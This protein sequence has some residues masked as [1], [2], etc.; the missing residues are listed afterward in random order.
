MGNSL[1]QLASTNLQPIRFISPADQAKQ[2]QPGT[3][4]C[5]SGGRYRAMVYHLGSLWR[6]NEAG[7]LRGLKRVSS[8]SGGSITA[9][10]LGLSGGN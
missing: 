1:N 8:V 4:L 9:A 7:L 10:M 2:P 3:A 6:L 5:L